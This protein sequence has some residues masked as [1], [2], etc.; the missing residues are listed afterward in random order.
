MDVTLSLSGDAL[1]TLAARALALGE[2][3]DLLELRLDGLAGLRRGELPSEA[4]LGDAFAALPRPWVA[5]CHRAGEPGV[6][7]GTGLGDDSRLELLRRAARAGARFVDVPVGLAERLGPLPEGSHRVLSRHLGEAPEDPDGALAELAAAAVPGDR[8]K[9]ALRAEDGLDAFRLLQ[10]LERHA[11]AGGVPA[12]AFATGQHG[13]P[14]RVLAPLFG[15]AFGLCAPPAGRGAPTAV[16]QPAL[17]VLRRAWPQG[18]VGPNTQFFGVI[19]SHVRHS[20]SPAVHTAALRELGHDAVYVHFET[21]HFDALFD[22]LEADGRFAGLSVTAPFKR[23]ALARASQADPVA[24]SSGAANTLVRV[25]GGFRAHNSDVTAL[26][27]ALTRARG[28]AREALVLGAGGAARAALEALR[29]LGWPRAVSARRGE[30]AAELAHQ[31]GARPVPWGELESVP[32]DVLVHTTN[33]GSPEAADQVAVEGEL[34][35][36]CLVLD[37]VYRPLNTPLLRKARAAGCEVVSGA[38]WF[39]LQAAEQVRLFHGV[40][41]APE[42]TM[43]RAFFEA[44]A[45][46]G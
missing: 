15:A 11:R 41:A 18:G 35:P 28:T 8:I 13:L 32:F 12:A 4:Q 2:R 27:S 40:D 22:L 10:A 9:L 21:A 38:D 6:V 45:A 36:G 37:A 1:D 46:D 16:G 44:L 33:L 43:A 26:E 23:A 20:L 39:L 14:T 42:D 30:A 19:G 34:P 3:A 17:D 25:P 5:A 24:L 29:R 31:F 7:G